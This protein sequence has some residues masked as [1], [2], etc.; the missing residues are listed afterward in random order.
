MN[1]HTDPH[2]PRDIIETKTFGRMAADIQPNRSIF[3][4]WVEGVIFEIARIPEEFPG[5]GRIRRA[6]RRR[7]P[8][9]WI[10]FCYDEHRVA[11]I[12]VEQDEQ[13]G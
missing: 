2:I 7:N 8:R 5:L 4:Q 11:L 12:H 13:T 6:I 9:L 1:G 3:D 10:I